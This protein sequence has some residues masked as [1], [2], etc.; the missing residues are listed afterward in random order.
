M[1]ATLRDDV[2]NPLEHPCELPTM[3][4][5]AGPRFAGRRDEVSAAF[6]WPLDAQ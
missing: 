1:V 4:G 6:R 2:M 3:R 5:A